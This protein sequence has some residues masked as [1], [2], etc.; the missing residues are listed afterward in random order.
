MR[1]G[2]EEEVVV[3]H[4]GVPRKVVQR[5]HVL[6]LVVVRQRQQQQQQQQQW[7]LHLE[8]ATT[9]VTPRREKAVLLAV[10]EVE[11]NVLA[12]MEQHW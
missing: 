1:R 3:E 6:Q 7:V 10:E 4:P 12:L 2:V 11:G 9:L 5:L 8:E